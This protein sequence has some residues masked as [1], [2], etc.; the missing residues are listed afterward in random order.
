MATNASIVSV[1]EY[2]HTNYKPA[3][4]YIDGVLR[5][6][7]MPTRKHGLIQGRLVYLITMGFQDFEAASEV[8]V[9]IRTGKY[10]VPDLVVQRC[11]RIQDPY[12]SEPVHLC[13]E[14]LSPEDLMSE[15]FAKCE[16]YHAWGVETAWVVDPED[17][18]AWEYRNGQRPAEV[19]G[20]GS[21]T[22][23]GISISLS[24]LFSVLRG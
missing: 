18:R 9:R 11:D 4:E 10:L 15:I 8:T 3:C 19:S 7:P 2:L 12:P 22:A 23:D 1:D 14:I 21:L 13:V 20:S 24:Q 17:R 5:Q 6:K 16:E